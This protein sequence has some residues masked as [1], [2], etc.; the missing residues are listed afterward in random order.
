MVP[1]KTM[2]GKTRS[3]SQGTRDPTL[4]P[5]MGNVI[6]RCASVLTERGAGNIFRGWR[7]ELDPMGEMKVTF[8]DFCK[9]ARDVG[10][11]GDAVEL[12]HSD[13]DGRSLTFGEVSADG[14]AVITQFKKWVKENFGS[15]EQLF[16]VMDAS[17]DQQV[18]EKEFRAFLK[19]RYFE[20]SDQ[21]ILWLFQ[22][23]DFTCEG[24]ISMDEVEFLEADDAIRQALFLTRKRR[25]E[26]QRAQ[27][28]QDIRVTSKQ[29]ELPQSHRL[30]ERPWMQC[31]YPHLP[32]LRR[33]M[34]MDARRV[35][36]QRVRE[37]K[38]SFLQHLRSYYGY[39]VRGWRRGLDPN[40]V[41]S[42][43]ETDFRRYCRKVDHPG[44]VGMLWSAFDKDN[45]GEMSFEDICGSQAAVLASF[46]NWAH[47]IFGS[48]AKFWDRRQLQTKVQWSKAEQRG[49]LWASDKKI[50]FEDFREVLQELDYPWVGDPG[51]VK[52]LL[53]S[54]DLYS[55]GFVSRQDLEWLDMWEPAEWLTAV[56][57]D[58]AWAEIRALLTRRCGT[59]IRAWTT[60]LDVNNSNRLS[61]R[62]FYQACQKLK[63]TG[64]VGGAW[65][66]LD[67]DLTGL[68]SLKQ[69]DHA[70][71]DVLLSFKEWADQFYGSV[72]N[73]FAALDVDKSGTVTY[74]ELR[75]ACESLMWKGKVRMLFDCLGLDRNGT[76]NGFAVGRVVCI[77]EVA[78]LD[79]W[80][81]VDISPPPSP[82]IRP[83]SPARTQSPFRAASS[84]SLHR[85][86]LL[87]QHDG[88]AK[89]TGALPKMPQ[90]GG[91][92]HVTLSLGGQNGIAATAMST[93][94][95]KGGRASTAMSAAS[96]AGVRTGTATSATPSMGGRA[97]TAVS[98]A[99]T[100][101]TTSSSFP[102]AG[103]V[104]LQCGSRPRAG[105]SPRTLAK[106][107]KIR[108]LHQTFCGGARSR[109]NPRGGSSPKS[110]WMRQLRL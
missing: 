77:K 19:E 31:R 59:M 86:R 94:P 107:E 46:R 37:E 110:R 41:Y 100:C 82:K 47:V 91:N 51:H 45:D 18:T 42:I 81:E 61:W 68:I 89:S 40:S 27:M 109:R 29:L 15:P 58:Y 80:L 108:Q 55:C 32:V 92:M 36:E 98:A 101:L 75:R 90:A 74:S 63:Y 88:Q 4:S 34:Q 49:R 102:P 35:K 60:L 5:R 71:Y 33:Q 43:S 67:K 78:F 48:C 85:D 62:E 106:Q 6:A 23:C 3:L 83:T 70:S 52:T 2:F 39:E 97:S 14:D 73:A 25:L 66:V 22:G 26:D 30:A 57:D 8:Q 50:L 79:D 38:Q 84:S 93:T 104:S 17:G 76:R 1:R 44:E 64:N 96:S 11:R 7:R 54:L 95:N 28:L 87:R 65:R 105:N 99:T 56:P 69:V 10:F 13:G 16:K 72:Q 21:Q 24:I 53:H 20:I 9:W 12:F 103:Q